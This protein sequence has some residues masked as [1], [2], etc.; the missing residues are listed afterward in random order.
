MITETDI[1]EYCF[2]NNK[3]L[4]DK[5]LT[6][7]ELQDHNKNVEEY[8]QRGRDEKLHRIIKDSCEKANIGIDLRNATR[9]AKRL[10]GRIYP[11]KLKYEAMARLLLKYGEEDE[12]AL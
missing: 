8:R 1:R 5:D 2:S 9:F 4:L 10:C 3:E 6:G 7:R 11:P 12:Q